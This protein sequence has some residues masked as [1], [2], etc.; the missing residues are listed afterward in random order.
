MNRQLNIAHK[1][2]SLRFV[3]LQKGL[4]KVHKTE[5]GES[6]SLKVSLEVK[7]LLEAAVI[8]DDHAEGETDQRDQNVNPATIQG[9]PEKPKEN[10]AIPDISQEKPRSDNAEEQKSE[11]TAILIHQTTKAPE[12][13]HRL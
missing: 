4:S 3:T 1:A 13:T 7:L 11:E 12:D 2:Q 5:M 9:E 8:V 10:T 6:I